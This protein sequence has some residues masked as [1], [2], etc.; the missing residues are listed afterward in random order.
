[1]RPLILLTFIALL[2]SP[3]RADFTINLDAGELTSPASPPMQIDDT[4][5]SNAG[6]LLLILDLGSSETVSNAVFKGNYVSGT[7]FILGAGGFNDEGGTNETL[8]TFNIT[9]GAN[10]SAGDVL[11]L[12]WFPQITFAQYKAGFATLGGMDY[13][14][15]TPGGTL[16]PDGGDLWVVPTSGLIDL[17]FYTTNSDFGGSEA[18]IFGTADVQVIP[19]PSSCLLLFFGL[20]LVVGYRWNKM[21]RLVE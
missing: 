17:N 20:L 7:N 5:G 16:T 15:Y 4:S 21:P 12:R 1:M 18:P 8:T 10:V 2:A 19:E 14:T 6:S 9:T 13:G 3:L 11:A